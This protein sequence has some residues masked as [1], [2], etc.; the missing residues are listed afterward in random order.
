MTHPRDNPEFKENADTQES[1]YKSSH[2]GQRI[3]LLA[4][5]PPGPILYD[6]YPL[7]LAVVTLKVM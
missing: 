2:S 5:L 4:C 6:P 3:H 7:P 1:S